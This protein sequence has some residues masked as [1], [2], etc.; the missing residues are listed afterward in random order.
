M[1]GDQRVTWPTD[2]SIEYHSSHVPVSA[3]LALFHTA[4]LVT[5]TILMPQMHDRIMSILR[6]GLYTSH[7][8]L[9]LGYHRS[10]RSIMVPQNP[11]VSLEA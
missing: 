3:E 9:V 10:C 1:E 6:H 7:P 5:P 11:L 8:A 2:E 4:I